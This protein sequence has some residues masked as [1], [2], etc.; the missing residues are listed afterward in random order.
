MLEGVLEVSVPVDNEWMCRVD[1]RGEP[2]EA[3]AV[4]RVTRHC[5]RS[6]SDSDIRPR[7][8]QE[9]SAGEGGVPC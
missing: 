5:H 6:A 4:T 2:R 8:P 3:V 1:G 7:I 9:Q